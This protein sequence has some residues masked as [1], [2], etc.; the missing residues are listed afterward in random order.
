MVALTIGL[1]ARRGRRKFRRY[2]RGNI[3]FELA[4]GTLGPADMISGN[5]GNTLTESA[6]LSS[7]KVS[8][9]LA[10]F[11]AAAGDGPIVIGIAHSGY[12]SA[13]IEGWIESASSWDQ[14][15]LVGNEVRKRHIRQIGIVNGNESDVTNVSLWAGM[16]TVK[17]GWG[18]TTGDTVKFWAYNSG[19]SL[20][21]TGSTL[22]VNGHANLWPN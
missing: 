8:I 7:V 21:T 11:T 12:T 9:A 6:W 19:S 14:G 13:E 1:M 3:D 20:L 17:C 15:N 16:R 22:H 2:I 4:L 5:E 18:L 10:D